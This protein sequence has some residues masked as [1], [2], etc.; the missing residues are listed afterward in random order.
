MAILDR[1]TCISAIHLFY[2]KTC[3]GFL[4]ISSPEH[5]WSAQGELLWSINVVRRASCGVNNCFKSNGIVLSN[6]SC[7]VCFVLLCL[8]VSLSHQFWMQNTE[9]ALS[10]HQFTCSILILCH[11]TCYFA[12]KSNDK[13]ATKQLKILGC[14]QKCQFLAIFL[15]WTPA[16][17][18]AWH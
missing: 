18:G 15:P 14:V 7:V 12:L 5:A 3:P 2:L 10:A 17:V 13:P 9:A 16:P 8:L 6:F 4:L 1:N 11:E